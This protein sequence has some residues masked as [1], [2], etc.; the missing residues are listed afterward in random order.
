MQTG[1]YDVGAAS[2]GA[3]VSVDVQV[4][5]TERSHVLAVRRQGRG[6]IAVLLALA[7]IIAAAI[8]WWRASQPDATPAAPVDE[9]L[10]SASEPTASPPAVPAARAPLV[11]EADAP[12]AELRVGQRTL[13]IGQPSKRV[14]V[15][16]SDAERGAALEIHARSDDGRTARASASGQTD[17]I[18]LTFPPSRAAAPPRAQPKAKIPPRGLAPM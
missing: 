1:I 5:A 15:L 14:E 7:A 4:E 8:L 10:G 2:A 13:A 11:V 18:E 17:R 3:T 6:R 12:I 9:P 16:L